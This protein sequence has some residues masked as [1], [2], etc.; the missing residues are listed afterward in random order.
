MENS[1]VSECEK[2]LDGKV[3]IFKE[4][5]FKVYKNVDERKSDKNFT[6]PIKITDFKLD[7]L[8]KLI[9]S[10]IPTVRYNSLRIINEQLDKCIYNDKVKKELLSKIKNQIEKENI[11]RIKALTTLIFEKKFQT[12]I[13]TVNN[14][15]SNALDIEKDCFWE[16]ELLIML[17]SRVGDSELGQNYL[18]K[19]RTTY[20]TTKEE[21]S[22]INRTIL[23]ARIVKLT[24]P[25]Q[26]SRKKNQ[27]SNNDDIDELEFLEN[28]QGIFEKVVEILDIDPKL[29]FVFFGQM[30]NQMNQ[31]GL[32]YDKFIDDFN[33]LEEI[34]GEIPAFNVGDKLPE[35]E[36]NQKYDY[37]L[38]ELLFTISHS[39]PSF[40]GY[41]RHFQPQKAKRSKDEISQNDINNILLNENS[42]IRYC[43]EWEIQYSNFIKPIYDH[44]KR[45][46]I[47]P[48]GP[49][50]R[51]RQGIIDAV[52]LFTQT[53]EDFKSFDF[54][55]EPLD[56]NLRN[57]L[58]HYNY[59]F[60]KD[61]KTL[62]YYNTYAEGLDIKKIPVKEFELKVL[63]LLIHKLI[64]NVRIAHKLSEELGTKWIRREK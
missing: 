16:F 33:K 40:F 39:I 18:N 47:L 14:L 53:K 21:E 51:G 20:N 22:L 61:G 32:R 1:D 35:K 19:Y 5:G 54:F 44:L 58:V 17:L 59:F 46:K 62:V 29:K 45:K 24:L 41:T 15:L 60:E 38:N 30:Y 3:M 9:Q 10:N 23:H 7:L 2:M 28:L 56:A 12:T 27:S 26:K 43:R 8:E 34:I 63:H 31:G 13:E 25:S 42:V 49:F 55:I 6:N 50:R 52:Y 57:S 64:F 37:L 36:R 4:I 48:I 11:T